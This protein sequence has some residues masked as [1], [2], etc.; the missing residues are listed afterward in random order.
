[1]SWLGVV[2]SYPVASVSELIHPEGPGKTLTMLRAVSWV[3][4]SAEAGWEGLQGPER[5]HFVPRLVLGVSSSS[6]HAGLQCAEGCKWTSMMLEVL[7]V[8]PTLA[9]VGLAGL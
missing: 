6:G 1:M 5:T 8:V 9:K 3:P 2:E 4:A 7:M